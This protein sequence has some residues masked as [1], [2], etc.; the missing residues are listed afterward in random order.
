MGE[1]K[2]DECY[3]MLFEFFGVLEK[4]KVFEE[5]VCYDVWIGV[6]VCMEVV[7]LMWEGCLILNMDEN[8]M[9]GCGNFWGIVC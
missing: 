2:V 3:E 9:N 4:L 5:L 6:V 1:V 7:E 8:W